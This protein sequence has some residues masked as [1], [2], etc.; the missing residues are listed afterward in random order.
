MTPLKLRTLA[1]RSSCSLVP[2]PQLMKTVCVSSVP[3]SA[4][5]PDRDTVPF[6]SICVRSVLTE[7]PLGA[8]LFTVTSSSSEVTPP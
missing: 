1:P 7:R 4:K 3:G 8:T 5:V 6:S 2:S